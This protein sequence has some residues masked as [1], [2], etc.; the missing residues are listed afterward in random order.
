MVYEYI[1]NDLI[2]IYFCEVKIWFG[3]HEWC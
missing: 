1:M 3:N 2:Y